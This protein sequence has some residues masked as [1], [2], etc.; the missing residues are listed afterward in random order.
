[1][2]LSEYSLYMTY[3]ITSTQR[4]RAKKIGVSIKASKLK[5]KKIAV[6]KNKKK[7]ADVGATGYK[8][9]DIYKKTKGKKFADNRRRLYK[10]RH[11]KTRRKVGSRSYYADKILW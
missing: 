6:F 11:Q 5:G 7:V 4:K 9:F 8:D 10:I 3:R 1:L 2:I